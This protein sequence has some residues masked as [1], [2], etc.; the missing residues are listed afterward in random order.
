MGATAAA[1]AIIGSS[2]L[3]TFYATAPSSQSGRM[4]VN[5]RRELCSE[6]EG[7]KEYRRPQHW[8]V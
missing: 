3:I 4:R 6:R 1:S 8:L 5:V 7:G 2:Y